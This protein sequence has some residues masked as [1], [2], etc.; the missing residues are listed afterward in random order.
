MFIQCGVTTIAE[1]QSRKRK[2][3]CCEYVVPSD[4]T[5]MRINEDLPLSFY[6]CIFGSYFLP[7]EVRE[8]DI[9]YRNGIT[10]F[11]TLRARMGAIMGGRITHIIDGSVRGLSNKMILVLEAALM[12]RR[13]MDLSGSSVNHVRRGDVLTSP[14]ILTRLQSLDAV[15]G[16]RRE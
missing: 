14:D 7:E 15:Y 1:L 2:F 4:A 16:L 6:R 10:S 9:L 12:M 3:I 5:L 13:C 11:E 8:R